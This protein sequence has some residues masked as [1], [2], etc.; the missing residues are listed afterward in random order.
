MHQL[1]STPVLNH[2]QLMLEAALHGRT[3]AFDEHLTIFRWGQRF[4]IVLQ[5]QRNKIAGHSIRPC[6]LRVGASDDKCHPRS[7]KIDPL[8]KTE[9]RRFTFLR[10]EFHS[11]WD[12]LVLW[13]S[14]CSRSA[15]CKQRRGLVP[16][17]LAGS[18]GDRNGGKRNP[19]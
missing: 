11:S 3:N 18:L 16:C 4:Q 10:L 2:S 9:E 15:E 13:G 6:D 14:A 1:D 12:T 17:Q 19:N 5:K 7:Q 8:V